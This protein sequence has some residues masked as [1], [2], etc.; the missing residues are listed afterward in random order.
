MCFRKHFALFFAISLLV[1]P[2]KSRNLLV[3]FKGPRELII[4]VIQTYVKVDI[5]RHKD[6][7]RETLVG[8]T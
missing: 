6:A 7:D 3:I 2:Q 8:D 5:K 4:S 1:C